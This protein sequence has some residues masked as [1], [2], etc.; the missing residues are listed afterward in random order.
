[1]KRVSHH[2]DIQGLD[3]LDIYKKQNIWMKQIVITGLPNNYSNLKLKRKFSKYGQILNA[4]LSKVS[5]TNIQYGIVEF[6]D[7]R[8]CLKAATDLDGT[9]LKDDL[10]VLSQLF[11]TRNFAN[12][13]FHTRK[14]TTLSI[15]YLPEKDIAKRLFKRLKKYGRIVDINCAQIK[16]TPKDIKWFHYNTTVLVTFET[17]VAAYAAIKAIHGIPFDIHGA[18]LE[19]K[20]SHNQI[21]V[22][23]VWHALEICN[24]I[25]AVIKVST[26]HI[27]Y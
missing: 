2:N 27:I 12:N 3:E 18:N 5:E 9:M 19:V 20:I 13:Q 7:G 21:Q 10:N 23:S 8:S 6:A 1:M 11:I 4:N 14:H 25:P 22:D 24:V 26:I 17:S 16:K 15:S